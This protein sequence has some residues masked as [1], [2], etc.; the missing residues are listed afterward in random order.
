M[1]LQVHDEL[2]FETDV[3]AVETATSVIRE[4]MESVA[5]LRVP[6]RVDIRA[7]ASWAEAH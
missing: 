4:E 7:G 2:L 5:A 1:I 3:A 6:L